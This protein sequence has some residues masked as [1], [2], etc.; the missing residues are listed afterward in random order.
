MAWETQ[1]F[2]VSMKAWNVSV[3]ALTVALTVALAAA[4][5]VALSVALVVAMAVALLNTTPA[6]KAWKLQT[7][8][9]SW[10]YKPMTFFLWKSST[11][12][13]KTTRMETT[14]VTFC[15]LP[16]L[17]FSIAVCPVL[18]CTASPS[19]SLFSILKIVIACSTLTLQR[20]CL[21]S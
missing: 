6:R 7:Q 3:V 16:A 19:S 8:S 1:S 12:D 20:K 14:M 5:T 13:I 18:Y 2:L 11:E 10:I 15:E 4:L 17:L 21:K 9:T